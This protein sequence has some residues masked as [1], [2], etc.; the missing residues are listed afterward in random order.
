[1]IS[2]ENIRLEMLNLLRSVPHMTPSH[3]IA[4]KVI[5]LPEYVQARVISSYVSHLNEQSTRSIIGH[6]FSAGK[7]VLIPV[8]SAH[9][10]M[11]MTQVDKD[12]YDLLVGRPSTYYKQQYGHSIPMPN[13]NSTPYSDPIDVALIPGLAFNQLSMHRIGYGYGHYDRFLSTHKVKCKIGLAHDFQLI[14]ESILY[15][16]HDIAMDYIVTDTRTITL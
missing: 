4:E 16:A 8:W 3:D 14:N 1:M 11:F 15:E 2:K 7:T 13:P 5:T 6:A 10:D 9:Q 12:E